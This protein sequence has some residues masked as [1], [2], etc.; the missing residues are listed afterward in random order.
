MNFMLHDGKRVIY[1]YLHL[2]IHPA[3]GTRA[4]I[5]SEKLSQIQGSEE[6]TKTDHIEEKSRN[7]GC[8]FF[9][10]YMKKGSTF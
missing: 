10:I 2:K 5:S 4:I 1:V 3:P 8:C 6:S 9:R 7:K